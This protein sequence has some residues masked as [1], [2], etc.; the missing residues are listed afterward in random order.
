MAVLNYILE[1]L[2]PYRC[3]GL[4]ISGHSEIAFSWL[5]RAHHHASQTAGIFWE[6]CRKAELCTQTNSVFWLLWGAQ[7]PSVVTA[8]TYEQYA[9]VSISCCHISPLQRWSWCSLKE[10]IA[11]SVLWTFGCSK[12][13]EWFISLIRAIKDSFPQLY[14]GWLIVET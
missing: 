13:S 4:W 2:W 12:G 11:C 14:L 9:I 8:S 5:R 6:G 3:Y 10:T 7:D 1:Y